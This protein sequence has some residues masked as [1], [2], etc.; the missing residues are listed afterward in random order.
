MTAQESYRQWLESPALSGDERAELLA[1]EKDPKEI[2]ERFFAPLDFGTA[3]LRGVMQTGLRCMNR[4]IVRRTTQAL[5]ELVLKEGGAERG[6]AVCYDTRNNSGAFAREAACVLAA[7]GIAVRLFDGPRPTPE[8]SFAIRRYG[9][10]AGINITA[11]HNPKQYN[12]YKVYW[13]DGAQLPP[14]HADAVAHERDRVSV[15]EGIRLITEREARDRGLLTV[16]GGETDESYLDAVFTQSLADGET[17]RAA[18]DMKIVYTPF[19]GC[20][21]ELVP[22]ILRRA[23][24]E[25]IVCVEEQ[26]T[27]DGDFPTVKSPNPEDKEGFALAIELAGRVQADLIIGTDPDADRVGIMVR[28][29]AS[30]GEQPD[31][32]DGFVTLSGNQTGVLLLDYIIKAR[33]RNGTM[34]GKPA[35]V[36]TVVTTPMAAAVAEGAGIPWYDTFTGFKFLAEKI[37]ELEERGERF[38]LAFEESYGFLAGDQARDK[39]AVVA[40]MLIA[41]MAAFYG[42]EGLTLYD[43]LEALYERY[44]YYREETV[45]LV[46]PGVDGLDRMKRLMRRLRGGG[47]P[48]AGTAPGGGE[49]GLPLSEIAGVQT[50]ALTDYQV[51]T[52]RARGGGAVTPVNPAGSDVLCYEMA[53]G[54]HYLIRPS[55]TEPKLKVYIMTRGADRDDGERRIAA[56]RGFTRDKLASV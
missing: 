56:Y 41:E 36:K 6:V 19:H 40:S 18:R 55:G 37:K 43:A 5:A 25:N 13:S 29:G 31:A 38:I 54:T 32:R 10:L 23:G 52:R 46:M 2:E 4:H 27:P 39:D 14:D 50:A 1:I 16:M 12:G 49:G 34:P 48:Q 22:R 15:F 47:A 45:N 44:G 8:L 17:R 30:E 24:F 3:G 51:G 9:C 7:N 20:G 21:R 42:A 28:R 35:F 33:Q 26:M 53:D 11:S